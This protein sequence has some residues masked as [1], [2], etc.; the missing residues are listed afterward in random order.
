[1]LCIYFYS[2]VQ[3][4]VRNENHAYFEHLEV[5]SS[6]LCNRGIDSNISTATRHNSYFYG[7]IQQVTKYQISVKIS[8]YIIHNN[9]HLLHFYVI[10]KKRNVERTWGYLTKSAKVWGIKQETT[11]QW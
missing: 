10:D 3:I 6:N 11:T 1:M 2:N 4:S 8:P 5:E 9:K 7:E